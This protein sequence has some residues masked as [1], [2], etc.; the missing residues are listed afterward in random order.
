[1]ASLP[2]SSIRKGTRSSCGSRLKVSDRAASSAGAEPSRRAAGPFAIAPSRT[3]G[4]VVTGQQLRFHLVSDER[5][6]EV[7]SLPQGA[8]ELPQLLELRLGLDPFGDDVVA[9]RR[10]ETDDRRDNLAR[11]L[12]LAHARDEDLVHL[13]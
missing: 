6:G 9:E 11:L 7:V 4:G 5:L 8:A 10:G 13:E 1:M 12:G 3:Q 2:G